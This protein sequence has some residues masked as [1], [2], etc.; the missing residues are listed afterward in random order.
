GA[1]IGVLLIGV[2]VEGYLFTKVNIVLRLI[3][4]A[5]ALCL[6]DSG[7]VTDMIGLAGAITVVGVQHFLFRKEQR[8]AVAAA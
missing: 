7:L 2:A 1:C 4:F 6:I 8:A 5:S 3:A